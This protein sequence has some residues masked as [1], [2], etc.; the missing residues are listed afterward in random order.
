MS[1]KLDS[2][3]LLKGLESLDDKTDIALRMFAETQVLS[4]QNDAKQNAQ[5]T[6]RTGHA[7]QRLKG[8]SGKILNGYRLTLSHGV[9]YGMWLELAKE[10]RYAIIEK[11]IRVTG[12]TKILPSFKK[13]LD[14][15]K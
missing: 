13:F 5:W 9:D 7:R 2:A 4:L 8:T 15:L 11:T 12:T 6:D 1:F 14:K 3:S 10:K